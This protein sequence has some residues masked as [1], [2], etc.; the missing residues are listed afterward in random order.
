[1]S[2]A[3]VNEYAM[4]NGWDLNVF[5]KNTWSGAQN[6]RFMEWA[7]LA[8]KVDSDYSNTT[9]FAGTTYEPPP[10]PEM[11]TFQPGQNRVITTTDPAGFRRRSNSF[12]I[13]EDLPADQLLARM[14]T[15]MQAQAPPDEAEDEWGD[16]DA[17]DREQEQEDWGEEPEPPPEE[18]EPIPEESMKPITEEPDVFFDE[19]LPAPTR[20]RSGT[21]DVESG[22]A[23]L[24]EAIADEPFTVGPVEPY[25]VQADYTA[26]QIRP[27]GNAAEQWQM[28]NAKPINMVGDLEAPLLSAPEITMPEL[29]AM[30]IPN[31]ELG[32]VLAS[33]FAGLDSFGVPSFNVASMVG[34]LKGGA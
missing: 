8:G 11:T 31:E 5:P 29:Q 34:E 19:P 26:G 2:I 6:Q 30:G 4:V 25:T 18:I 24:W 23:P 22:R 15:T 20:V 21:I 3:L 16:D 12:Y 1:M 32:A 33:S 10:P 13:D 17:D 14:R 9:G 28:P 7:E 27:F